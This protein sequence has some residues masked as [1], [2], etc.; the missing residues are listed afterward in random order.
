MCHDITVSSCIP[1]YSITDSL[2][3]R[4]T[5]SILYEKCNPLYT[6][7]YKFSAVNTQFIIFHLIGPANDQLNFNVHNPRQ[8]S[9]LNRGDSTTEQ[10]TKCTVLSKRSETEPVETINVDCFITC[11]QSA[12][13]TLI[14]T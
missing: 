10:E 11:D 2:L 7:Q 9:L 6:S 1:T 8:D 13:I 12:L 5:Y 14:Q 3:N 4:N